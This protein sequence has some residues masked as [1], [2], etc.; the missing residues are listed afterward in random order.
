M[1]IE[2]NSSLGG[3]LFVTNT[4]STELAKRIINE[5]IQITAQTGYQQFT[6]KRLAAEIDTTED[7][8]HRYFFN[9][10]NT[11]IKLVSWYWAGLEF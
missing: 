4:Q 8:V 5:A 2:F 6:F 1:N 9:K 3:E 7:V 11:L 10:H